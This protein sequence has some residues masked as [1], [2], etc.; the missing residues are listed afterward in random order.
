MLNRSAFRPR[1]QNS[2]RADAW[3]RA[4]GF[5]RWLRGRTCRLVTHG[6]CG[7]KVRACHV[8]YAGDKGMATKVHDKHALP[9]CDAHHGIQHG[10]GWDT[11]EGNYK[12]NALADAEA[13]WNAW[14][15]RL[16]WELERA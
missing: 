8:D 2:H 16:A 3:K 9:M 6:G 12:I 15:G 10:V 7:G 13:Y 5:L 1:K 11:F 14:P 4:P